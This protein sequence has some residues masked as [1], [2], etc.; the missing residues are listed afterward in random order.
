[1]NEFQIV[2]SELLEPIEVPTIAIFYFGHILILYLT[3]VRL[4][5]VAS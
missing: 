4:V 5:E 3:N 1:M 2:I